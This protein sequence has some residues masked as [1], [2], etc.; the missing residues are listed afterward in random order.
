[1]HQ[2][3]DF[4]W[5]SQG[6]LGRGATMPTSNT[7]TTGARLVHEIFWEANRRGLTLDDLEQI[8][9]TTH[10]QISYRRTCTQHTVH[11]Q[12]MPR[13]TPRRLP[14]RLRRLGRSGLCRLRTLRRVQGCFGLQPLATSTS[15]PSLTKGDTAEY[16]GHHP[17]RGVPHRPVLQRRPH[18]WQ[19][20]RS[21]PTPTRR[22]DRAR[23]AEPLAHGSRRPTTWQPPARRRRSG[24]SLVNLFLITCTSPWIYLSSVRQ[25]RRDRTGRGGTTPPRVPNPY[26]P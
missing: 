2:V 4:S 13:P 26:S 15:A 11:P 18:H 12:V 23:L 5:Y 22:L 21:L 25:L 19:C 8:S 7:W 24:M 3:S 9:I 16:Q 14:Q 10:D 6:R 1:M 20:R 17:P